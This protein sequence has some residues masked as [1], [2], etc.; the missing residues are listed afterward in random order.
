MTW[1]RRVGLGLLPAWAGFWVWFNVAS[2]FGEW[3]GR[4]SAGIEVEARWVAHG[5]SRVRTTSSTFRP[6]GST[7]RAPQAPPSTT[8]APSTRTWNSP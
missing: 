4:G 6:E 1:V 3:S 2:A 8:V 5:D 7:P